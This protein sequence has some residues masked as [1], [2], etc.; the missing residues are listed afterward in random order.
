MWEKLIRTDAGSL[1]NAACFRAVTAAV[2]AKAPGADA[3]RLAK[4]DADRA[5]DWLTKS[6]T[7]GYNDAAHMKKDTDLDALREREDFKKLL[8]ALP[9]PREIAPTPR[10]VSESAGWPTRGNAGV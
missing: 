1:Y 7:A 6:V 8:N 9:A 2:Q 5:M 10:T 3:A 4:E